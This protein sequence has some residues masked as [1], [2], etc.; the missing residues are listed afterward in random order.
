MSEILCDTL[1]AVPCGSLRLCIGCMYE[2]RG[3]D[4]AARRESYLRF[5][6][7]VTFFASNV[8]GLTSFVSF[9]G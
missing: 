3:V 7:R 1:P 8:S 5:L 4:F 2:T 6:R 9:L